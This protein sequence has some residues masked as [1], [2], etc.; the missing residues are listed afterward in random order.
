MHRRK[1]LNTGP[2]RPAIGG[3][4]SCR[5][6]PCGQDGPCGRLGF[7]TGPL[8]TISSKCRSRQG[9]SVARGR[10]GRGRPSVACGQPDQR[11]RAASAPTVWGVTSA[12]RSAAHQRPRPRGALGARESGQA[13]GFGPGP[14][15]AVAR[16]PGGAAVQRRCSLGQARAGAA[17]HGWRARRP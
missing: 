1:K 4:I 7:L 8:S 9:A 15:D 2:R 17:L 10:H 12:A 11:V 16:H 5:G 3:P 13:D 14:D 6:S